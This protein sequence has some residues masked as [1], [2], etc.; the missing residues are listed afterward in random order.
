MRKD[1]YGS[2]SDSYDWVGERETG[3]NFKYRNL[4]FGGSLYEVKIKA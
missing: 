3:D 4:R 2:N 1:Q